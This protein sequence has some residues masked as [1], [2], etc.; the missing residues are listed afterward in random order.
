MKRRSRTESLKWKKFATF[1]KKEYFELRKIKFNGKLLEFR[2]NEDTPNKR[3]LGSLIKKHFGFDLENFKEIKLNNHVTQ[4][5]WAN[6]HLFKQK[7]KTNTVFYMDSDYYVN[8]VTFDN[9]G[10]VVSLIPHLFTNIQINTLN[11]TKFGNNYVIYANYTSQYSTCY[12]NNKPISLKGGQSLLILADSCL[13]LVKYESKNSAIHLA[14]N[15]S[16]L[17]KLHFR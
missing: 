12:F 7:N 2:K 6:L 3:L 11:V 13:N 9:T 17:A 5:Y 1:N 10:R 4:N 8:F 14:A 16:N 15:S